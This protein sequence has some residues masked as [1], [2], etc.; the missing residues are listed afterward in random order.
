MDRAHDWIGWIVV[1]TGP[2]FCFFLFFL[3]KAAESETVDKYGCVLDDSSNMY[4]ILEG[5]RL[6]YCVSPAGGEEN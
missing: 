6:Q 2:V 3:Q 4:A 1:K 5:Q